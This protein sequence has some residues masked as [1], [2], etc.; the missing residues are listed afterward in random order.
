MANRGLKTLHPMPV[1]RPEEALAEHYDQLRAWALGLTRG[2]E[3][4]SLDIVHDLYLYVLLAKPDFSRIKNLDSYLYKCLR[5]LHIAYMAKS[6][7]LGSQQISVADIESIQFAL[8]TSPESYVLEHQNEL[9]RICQYVI[10]RKNQT[11]GASFFILRFFHDYD[12]REIG[13]IANLSL[14]LVRSSLSRMRT[15]VQHY[16]GEPNNYESTVD[17][18]G[19]I[20]WTTVSSI[21]L[22]RHLRTMIMR[23][24]AGDCLEAGELL[25]HYQALVPKPIS[26]ALLSHIVSCE[27]C[28]SIIDRHF[29]RPTLCDRE[30]LNIDGASILGRRGTGVKRKSLS[31]KDLLQ[32]VLRHRKDVYEHYPRLLSIAVDGKIIASHHVQGQRSRQSARVERPEQVGCIEVYSEEDVRLILILLE[33]LPPQ[34]PLTKIE[35][36]DLSDGRW[37][38]MRITFDSV[39]LISE[40]I[41]FDPTVEATLPESIHDDEPQVAS[42]HTV[43]M[44]R[45]KELAEEDQVARYAPQSESSRGARKIRLFRQHRQAIL[46]FHL[47]FRRLVIAPLATLPRAAMAVTAVVL[48]CVLP[49]MQTRDTLLRA[50]TILIQSAA[51]QYNSVTGSDQVL[52]RSFEYSE[53]RRSAHTGT[54]RRVEVWCLPRSGSEVKRLIDADG[55]VLAESR[56]PLSGLPT[57]S[58]AWRYDPSPENYR[59]LVMSGS[60]TRIFESQTALVLKGPQAEISFDRTSYRPTHSLLHFSDLEVEF[61]EQST[62]AERIQD[63]PFAQVVET[64]ENKLDTK[65]PAPAP[66]KADLDTSELLARLRLHAL[67]ADLGEDLH[68]SRE[69]RRVAITGTVA[70][71]SRLKELTA[72]LRGI[73]HLTLSLRTPDE[74]SSRPRTKQA[75]IKILDPSSSAAPLL[76]TWLRKKFPDVGDRSTFVNTVLS[77]SER[78]IWRARALSELSD[79]YGDFADPSVAAIAADHLKALR[80]E[81]AA[82]N[83][84]FPGISGP[85]ALEAIDN[86]AGRGSIAG[87]TRSLFRSVQDLNVQLTTLLADH[88]PSQD[89]QEHTSEAVM[90]ACGLDLRTIERAVND[91]SKH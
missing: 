87:E 39:G 68:I 29:R 53:R 44:G 22:F 81:V 89:G 30:P 25:E 47:K 21:E 10:A 18:S 42:L 1:P 64:H 15:E 40:T 85:S 70:T 56:A 34:G 43:R 65:L 37:I 41:Y 79:R 57:P 3:D 32:V 28:L 73:P 74:E 84:E 88:D 66:E 20:Q 46:W 8:W 4:V 33:D 14:A 38:E 23:A 11:K 55:R 27:R 59:P 90:T 77:H 2:D 51:W 63:T 54:K 45:V 71:D 60:K 6:S 49:V 24:R 13:E 50:E 52:H 26:C 91:L 58:T 72:Q 83:G 5:H 17:T 69:V 36:V 31:H 9:R 48:I 82:L 75:H 78:M 61:D 19:E 7:R 80:D 62:R 86:S 35:H 12:L 67:N 76:A 16:L